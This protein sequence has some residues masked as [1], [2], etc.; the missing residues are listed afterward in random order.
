M[1][2][3]D[4]TLYRS[5]SHS[6]IGRSVPGPAASGPSAAS[7]RR[8]VSLACSSAVKVIPRASMPGYSG[9]VRSIGAVQ[10][11]ASGSHGWTR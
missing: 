10:V 5:V 4:R 2:R 7:S 9:R 8:A 3:F 1:T 11:S 6:G